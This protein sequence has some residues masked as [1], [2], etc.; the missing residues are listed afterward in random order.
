MAP[1]KNHQKSKSNAAPKRIS[2]GYVYTDLIPTWIKEIEDDHLSDEAFF[3]IFIFF[4]L[5]SPYPGS[6]KKPVPPSAMHKPVTAYG[7][8]RK[9]PN[10]KKPDSL[11]YL[12]R[13]SSTNFSLIY[14][15]QNTGDMRQ[16]LE[17]SHHLDHFPSDLDH[18]RVAVSIS[19][20][21]QFHSIFRHIRNALSHGRFSIEKNSNGDTVYVLEDKNTNIPKR[22]GTL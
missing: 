20:E 17:K 8:S 15:A 4:V 6:Y 11:N 22:Q 9:W 5:D 19:D 21:N 18:E 14:S 12:L 13:N 10:Y 16:A 3:K 1:V 2:S 7:W